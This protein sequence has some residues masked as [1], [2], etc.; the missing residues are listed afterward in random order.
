MLL[1]STAIK[2]NTLKNIKQFELR[3]SESWP[4][5]HKEKTKYM[6]NHAGSEDTLLPYKLSAA[7]LLILTHGSFG[8]TKHWPCL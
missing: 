3:K 7:S 4:K 5:I 2:L 8:L 6:T 1:F